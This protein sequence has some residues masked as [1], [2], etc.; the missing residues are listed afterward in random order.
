MADITKKKWSKSYV[1]FHSVHSK[2]LK[3][4]FKNQDNEIIINM[5]NYASKNWNRFLKKLKKSKNIKNIKKSR[6]SKVWSFD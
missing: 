5:K 6:K 4:D 1:E 3:L 2:N